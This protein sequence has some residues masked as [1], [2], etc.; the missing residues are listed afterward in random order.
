LFCVGRKTPHL[1]QR[2]V[3][4]VGFRGKRTGSEGGGFIPTPRLPTPAA[5]VA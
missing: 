5:L 2:S 1:K 4:T 3:G